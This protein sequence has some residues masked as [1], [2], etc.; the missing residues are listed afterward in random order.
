MLQPVGIV[1]ITHYNQPHIPAMKGTRMLLADASELTPPI[2]QFDGFL[3][4]I[5]QSIGLVGVL[6]ILWGLL[7]ALVQLGRLEAAAMRGAI[8]P[9]GR[10]RLRTDLGYYLLL[11]L[12]FLVA[13]DVVETIRAPSLEHLAVL[14]AIVVIRTAISI[15]L[16]WELAQH[17]RAAEER[18]ASANL[19]TAG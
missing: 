15:S 16:N 4:F 17:R 18:D 3:H 11:G 19:E 7:R 13:A 5:A 6:V 2:A 10:E 8:D 1:F 9:Q 14:G 12:E